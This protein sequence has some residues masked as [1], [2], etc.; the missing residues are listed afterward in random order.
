VGGID[1]GYFGKNG[2]ATIHPVCWWTDTM[3]GK[4]AASGVL[5]GAPAKQFRQHGWK[6]DNQPMSD[7]F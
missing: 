2:L 7:Y 4:S 6:A 5:S 1:V 3:A